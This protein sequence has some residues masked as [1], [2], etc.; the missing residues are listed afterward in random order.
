MLLALLPDIGNIVATARVPP[1]TA[2]QAALWA[3]GNRVQVLLLCLRKRGVSVDSTGEIYEDSLFGH[4]DLRKARAKEGKLFQILYQVNHGA[5]REALTGFRSSVLVLHDIICHAQTCEM[6]AEV[7]RQ[8]EEHEMLIN[9]LTGLIDQVNENEQRSVTTPR[10]APPAQQRQSMK[11]TPGI[12]GHGML[13]GFLM[14]DES[15]TSIATALEKLKKAQGGPLPAAE[16]TETL[17]FL[18]KASKIPQFVPVR[19]LVD[20]GATLN[21]VSEKFVNN[22]GLNLLMKSISP[23]KIHGI[24]GKVESEKTIELKWYS[25]SDP[26]PRTDEFH[27]ISDCPHE[28]LL[29]RP[30]WKEM[31]IFNFPIGPT[32]ATASLMLAKRSKAQKAAEN[33]AKL[34]K[35]HKA[36]QDTES[37]LK[38]RRLELDGPSSSSAEPSQAKEQTPQ[39]PARGKSIPPET[40]PA[41][42]A[43][44]QLPDSSHQQT[45]PTPEN[46]LIS[47]ERRSLEI[48]T[49]IPAPEQLSSTA[50]LPASQITPPTSVPQIAGLVSVEHPV[51]GDPGASH[52]VNQEERQELDSG[53]PEKLHRFK[54]F[55]FSATGR[56]K[57]I[58]T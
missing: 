41:V 57:K 27:V 5:L 53:R 1:S 39:S 26:E 31:N 15:A 30:F 17:N 7:Q 18:E 45:N 32:V 19:F 43:D 14:K 54:L 51:V 34:E 11:E 38:E 42:T 13:T 12:D 28:A 8:H 56:K 3:C 6:L 50:A 44:Q 23:A 22:H 10:D 20:S 16:L 4:T 40:P 29:G 36:K 9:H 21:I 24:G 33:F 55:Y 2:A 35:N 47:A 37:Y 46:E 52:L 48:P 49:P 25:D 58:K